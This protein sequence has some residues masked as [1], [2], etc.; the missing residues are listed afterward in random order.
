MSYENA[1]ATQMLATTCCACGRP[2]L[3]SASV[4]AGMGPDCRSKYGVAS[5]DEETRKA[6][7]VHIYHI[8][9]H[10]TGPEVASRLEALRQLGL[11]KL[12]ERIVKRLA[13]DYLAVFFDEGDR[14][15][16]R[17][18]YEVG[19]ALFGINGRRWEKERKLTTFPNGAKRDVFDALRR[20]HRGGKCIG[21]KG[22]FTLS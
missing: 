2:L 5:L 12:V 10:Q 17:A 3:D 16:V 6:A 15:A 9:L 21:P 11:V 19:Q 22:E 20:A 1:P 8:A 4:T 14:F 13:P 7:N 18:P